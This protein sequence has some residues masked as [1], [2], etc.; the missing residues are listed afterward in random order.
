MR[1]VVTGP[2]IRAGLIQ[3][4]QARTAD[5]LEA[6]AAEV[7]AGL[8]S[9]LSD[10][11]RVSIATVDRGACVASLLGAWRAG[12]L[13]VPLG[14][15]A[16][17]PGSVDHQLLLARLDDTAP[18]VVLADDAHGP[19]LA[20]AGHRREPTLDVGPL[21]G[22]RSPASAPVANPDDAALVL[23]TSGSTGRPKGV[24]ISPHALDAIAATNR[25]VYRFTPNDRFLSALPT[26]HLA[27]L[28]NLLAALSDGVEVVV[29]PPLVFANEVMA[30][31]DEHRVTVAGLVPH[32]LDQ[33]LGRRSDDLV[34]ADDRL[35]S[36]RLIVS[37]G[38]RLSPTV[39][40]AAGRA[41]PQAEIINAYG[42]TEA[43][44]S[45]TA[46]ADPDGVDLIGNP[47]VGV[48]ARLVDPGTGRP[49]QPGHP[50]ELQ[51]RG[52]N[53]YGGYWRADGTVERPGRWL[54]TG[55][56]AEVD[57][58]G[59]FRLIGRLGSFVNVGGHKEAVE[60]IEAVLD[61]LAPGRLAITPSLD[62]RGLEQ[63]ALVAEVGTGLDL[64]SVRRHAARRLAPALCPTS[65]IE[66][67]QLPRTGLGKLDRPTL[68]TLIPSTD[69]DTDTK[70]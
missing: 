50:G 24:V 60:T 46:V 66:V 62:D 30:T 22:W 15:A 61:E 29:A 12:Q 64:R 17:R 25:R 5:Q 7:A 57:D 52:P 34:E 56:L 68:A 9:V 43:F 63:I 23:F 31:I 33:L 11:G 27:G 14:E 18:A 8:G 26:T 40:A 54:S 16:P 6:M 48:E 67:D 58:A 53:L 35:S 55:D 44:R 1:G 10:P 36:L 45:F 21:Q 70:A 47:V 42:L 3:N 19:M 51:L 69:T 41:A 20:E 37:S 4:G 38:A 32:Q 59:R 28:T 49:S 13:P 65:L 39:L 2:V